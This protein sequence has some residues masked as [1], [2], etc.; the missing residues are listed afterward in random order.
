[1]P[2]EKFSECYYET[3]KFTP[4]PTFMSNLLFYMQNQLN[5]CQK[6]HFWSA[7]PSNLANSNTFFIYLQKMES[8]I[9]TF[10]FI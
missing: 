9:N 2:N 7:R 10:N 8:K 3:N 5:L 6:E 1:M 4:N